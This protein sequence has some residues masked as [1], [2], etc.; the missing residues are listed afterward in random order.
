[1]LEIGKIYKCTSK[2]FYV[3]PDIWD[4]VNSYYNFTSVL[5]KGI[6]TIIDI[7]TEHIYT[8]G[9]YEVIRLLSNGKIYV[10]L[11]CH[12]VSKYWFKYFKKLC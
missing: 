6:I 5:I 1:M 4:N 2:D 9:D 11:D 10:I 3:Y 8:W 12:D 7:K